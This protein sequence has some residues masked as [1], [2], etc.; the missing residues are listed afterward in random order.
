MEKKKLLRKEMA[1]TKAIY[2]KSGSLK[3]LSAEVLQRL[4]ACPAFKAAK[5]VML[6]YALPDEVDTH[7][8]VEQWAKE[9]QII[10][11]V[12]IGDDLELRSYHGRYELAVGAYGIEEPTGPAFTEEE[13]IECIVVPGVAFDRH[14]NRL[15]RGKGYY[16]RLLPRLPQAYKI[17]LCFPFQ[18]V[19]EV[20]AEPFDIP[21]D[22]V[23]C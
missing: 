4:E 11:P 3:E 19:D 21:M 16:D 5:T 13:R 14:G 8:F 7:N 18:L 2:R 17:G 9:K 10:L 23:I 6:Y 1:A 12:V 20:P 22:E 15:G